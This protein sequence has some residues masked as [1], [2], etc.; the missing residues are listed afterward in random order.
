MKSLRNQA[1]LFRGYAI[2]VQLVKQPSGSV[3]L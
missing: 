3:G 2:H 1:F